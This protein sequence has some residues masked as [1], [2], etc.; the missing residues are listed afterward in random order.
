MFHR[1]SSFLRPLNSRW[2]WP[3]QES[4]IPW[5]GHQW[6]S[7]FLGQSV[8]KYDEFV[9]CLILCCHYDTGFNNTVSVRLYIDSN[10]VPWKCQDVSCKLET[11]VI[12]TSKRRF[13]ITIA[14]LLRSVFAGGNSLHYQL[15]LMTSDLMM[16]S[17]NGN[18]FRVTD[19]CGEFTGNRWIPF[20][21]AGGAELRCFL[22]SVPEKRLSKQSKLRWFETQSRSLWRHSNDKFECC[23]MV[24]SG[25]GNSRRPV[26][27]HHTVI[28]DLSAHTGRHDDVIKWKHFPRYW[29]FVRG[30]HRS[31]VNSPH[32][33]QWHGA[34]MFSLIC[35]RI[36][37]WVNNGEA[38]DLRRHRAHYEV[39]VM[40]MMTN[41][42]DGSISNLQTAFLFSV[43]KRAVGHTL[44]FRI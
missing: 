37:G 36:N 42:N 22:W 31:P 21:K 32:K 41:Q 11:Y 1:C 24:A 43:N 16:T 7:W 18:I 39:T 25:R 3:P 15:F 20:T 4:H 26:I 9:V 8:D 14:C 40:T 12:I 17:S 30:I 19:L 38:G 33:G 6:P 5:S 27:S 28:W 34:L 23:S 2:G 13:D 35:A 44:G 10:V 29:P